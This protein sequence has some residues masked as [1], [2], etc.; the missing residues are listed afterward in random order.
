MPYSR[1]K[2]LTS[3]EKRL[4]LLRT[5][6]YG[7][8]EGSSTVLPKPVNSS[9]FSFKIPTKS[10]ESTKM[11]TNTSDTHYLRH[12]LLKIL[13]LAILAVG[14]EAILYIGINQGIIK[15]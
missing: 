13:L 7:K 12:D 15:L 2:K 1:S 4:Q 11:L 8:E 14:I 3:T 9:A 5:Q 10:G 6:L